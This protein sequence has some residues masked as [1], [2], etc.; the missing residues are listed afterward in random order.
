MPGP[1]HATGRCGV[2]T[3]C[4]SAMAEPGRRD[5][6][7]HPLGR[8][9]GG[10]GQHRQIGRATRRH[11][12]LDAQV[13]GRR[14]G[15]PPPAARGASVHLAGPRPRRGSR[16]AP[17]PPGGRRPASPP[18]CRPGRSSRG[19]RSRRSPRRRRSPA[20]APPRRRAP[21][22]IPAAVGATPAR[23]MSSASSLSSTRT[24]RS[25]SSTTTTEP[26]PGRCTR[27]SAQPGRGQRREQLSATSRRSA[28]PIRVGRSR[29]SRPADGA[30]EPGVGHSPA[31][32]SSAADVVR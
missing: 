23:V 30:A 13:R 25:S 26:A 9:Q 7:E 16:A 6:P 17:G 27:S 19:R 31:R 8:H 15:A 20:G 14:R 4:M 10:G 1:A 24:C 21:P 32:A 5:P 3:T 11:R 28:T 29:C 18:R 12:P 22:T 2:T